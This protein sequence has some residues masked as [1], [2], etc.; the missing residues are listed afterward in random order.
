MDS[1]ILTNT[2]LEKCHNFSEILLNT[3]KFLSNDLSVPSTILSQYLWFTKH[4]KIGNN[5]VYFS[6]FSNHDINFIGN[7]VD[8]W[9]V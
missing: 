1:L 3:G 8:N 4:V 5:S 6:H 2:L 7:L 9:K